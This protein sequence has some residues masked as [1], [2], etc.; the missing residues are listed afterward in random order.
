MS[1][2][3]ILS[4]LTIGLLVAFSSAP[5]WAGESPKD[6]TEFTI[7]ANN[8]LLTQLPFNDKRDF[9]DAQR[10]FIAPLKDGGVLKNEKGQVMYDAGNYKFP[11][12]APA[13]PTVNPSFWRQSQVNGISGLFKV[14]DRIYQ[15][16]GQDIS[17]I[18]FIEGDS[19]VIIVDPLLNHIAAKNALELYFQ[20]RPKKMIAAVIY[21]HSHSDHFGGVRGIITDED[22]SSGKTKVIAPKGF[23]EE[24][25]SENVLA[26][27]VMTRRSFYSYGLMLPKNAKG[28]IGNGL[29]VT[30]VASAPTLIAPTDII[31]ETGQKMTIDGLEFEFLLAPGSEAPAEMH[32]YIPALKA[33]TTAENACHTLHNLYTLRGAKTRDTAKWVG[34]LNE[35]LDRWGGEAEI[36]YMPHTWPVFGNQRIYEHV[37]KYRDTLKYI[38]DQSLHLANQGY[39]MNEIGNMIELPEALAQNWASRGYYG[40]VSHNARAVYNFYLGYFDG[41]PANL[42]PYSPAEMAT[43]YVRTFGTDDMMKAG[44]EALKKGD[45]RWAA[46]VLKQVVLADPNNQEARNLQADA[47]EQLGYQ[48]ES[49]TWRGFY[50]SGAQELRNGVI[51]AELGAADSPDMVKNM[52]VEMLFDYLAVLLDSAKARDK[53][54]SVAFKF[55]DSRDALVLTLKN[56]VLNYRKV[57]PGKADA[58]ITIKRDDLRA[59]LLR[60]ITLEDLVKNGQATIEGSASKLAE[61]LDSTTVPDHWFNIVTPN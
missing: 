50:L 15:V 29:G 26:G 33:L 36:L 31:T 16:R 52:P 57:L 9:E 37:E 10:G 45:Y 24:A 56:S 41:N 12:D 28:T 30:L 14:A 55:S 22:V 38:H 40:S 5:T 8:A 53:D 6:A 11:L 27:N 4:I 13:P 44:R 39:T 46:E 58:T 2:K 48:A 42:D 18:T 51:K 1:R 59:V 21:T 54:I 7:K 32:F 20:H 19:G 60:Q 47:F 43:R 25:I 17:N 3:K 35:T 23:L 61:L 34:Y 49:A